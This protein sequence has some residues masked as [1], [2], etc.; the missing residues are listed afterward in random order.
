MS[1][2]RSD[3]HGPLALIECIEIIGV[4][5]PVPRHSLGESDTGNVFNTFHQMNELLA[6]FGRHRC[7]ANTAIAGH[8][9]GNSVRYRWLE[10]F[11]PRNLPIEMRMNIDES[12][13]YKQPG[14]VDFLSAVTDNCSADLSQHAIGDSEISNESCAARAVDD[15]AIPDYQIMSSH[16]R[17]PTS[18]MQP[19]PAEV[20]TCSPDRRIGV[21]FTSTWRTPSG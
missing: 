5:H 13:S 4:G 10:D 15:C 7:E 9:R 6:A 8:D 16:R 20:S 18:T 11:V 3:I 2:L 12:W 21:P 19:G 1:D 14:G 17:R